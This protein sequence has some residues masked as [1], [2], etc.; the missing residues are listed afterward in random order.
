MP[1]IRLATLADREAFVRLRLDLFRD[2]GELC[3]EAEAPAMSAILERYFAEEL[4]PGRFHAWLAFDDT[5][6]AV[7]SG[8]LIFIQKPPLPSNTSGREGYLMNMYTAPSW[9]GRGVARGIVGTILAFAREAGVDTVRLHASVPGR[10][11]YERAGF[12][13]TD[14]E[15][16]I[17]LK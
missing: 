13:A 2:L 5:G 10:P 7:G 3:D 4:P 11:V 14:S 9:R 1:T 16:V 12:T 17:T 6:V 8:G 15:M